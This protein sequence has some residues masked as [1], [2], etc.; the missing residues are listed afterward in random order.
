[1]ELMV[2]D[3]F[4][5]ASFVV[6]VGTDRNT[7]DGIFMAQNPM[8]MTKEKAKKEL[9]NYWSKDSRRLYERH[10]PFARLMVRYP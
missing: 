3:I 9:N 10:K 8:V 6:I 4:L 2:G 1:M 7:R 5:V